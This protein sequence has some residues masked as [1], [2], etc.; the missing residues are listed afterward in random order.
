MCAPF[1]S[2]VVFGTFA[3]PMCVQ[4]GK[5]EVGAQTR[6]VLPVKCKIF[7]PTSTNISELPSVGRSVG[8]SGV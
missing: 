6:V 1:L 8:R 3:I 2:A 4:R 5:A 7:Q